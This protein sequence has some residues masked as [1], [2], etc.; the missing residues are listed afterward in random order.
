VVEGFAGLQHEV[1]RSYAPDADTILSTNAHLGNDLFKLW[2]A[3]RTARGTRLLVHQH[4]GNYGLAAFSALEDYEVSIAD[5]FLSWG[6][7][8]KNDSTV[9]AMPASKLVGVGSRFKPNPSGGILV[10]SNS[11][12]LNFYRFAAMPVAGQN[13]QFVDDHLH[14]FRAL[15]PSVLAQTRLR[16]YPIDFGWNE[17]AR[18]GDAFP[19]L[20]LAPLSE[21]FEAQV[22]SSRLFI[23]TNNH[24]TFLETLAA[25]FPTL[26]F[27][28]PAHWELRADAQPYFDRLEQAG[29]WHRTPESAAALVNEIAADPASWWRQSSVQTVRREFCAR[30]ARTSPDWCRE[31]QAQLTGPRA[32]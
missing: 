26:L 10:A 29:L 16:L 15:S 9:T 5:R 20:R 32:H 17:A 7:T 13:L 24:T 19:A 2:T 27:W 8:R 31:W 3:A 11:V 21:T 1:S 14:F 6:W 28:N 30:F 23:S 12:P 25:D 4:G 18:Y 22:N